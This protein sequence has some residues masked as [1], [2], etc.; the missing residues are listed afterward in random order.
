MYP[1]CEIKQHCEQIILE[2]IL[3]ISK[4]VF[5]NINV[6]LRNIKKLKLFK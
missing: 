4:H 3:G 2:E 6:V 1:S 5:S